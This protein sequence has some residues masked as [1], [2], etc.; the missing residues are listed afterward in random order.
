[1]RMHVVQHVPFEGPAAIANWAE[2]RGVEITASLALT[3]EYPDIDTVDFLVLMGGPMDAD[4]HF[5]SPWLEAEKTYVARALAE[6]RRVLGVCLGAQIVAEAIGGH[7]RRNDQ[8]EIG[9]FAL[10][11]NAAADNDPV[12]A[13]LPEALIAGHWHGD[14]F[15][16]PAGV[17]PAL[18]S[19]GTVCQAF[20][21]DRGRV[22]G[23]QFHLEWTAE[24]LAALLYAAPEDLEERS[25]LVMSA[26]ELE[27]GVQLHS[28]AC[29]TAL[30][31]LL[32]S[33]AAHREA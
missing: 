21:Y 16:L 30:W 14:T 27:R 15:D 24:S 33:M 12:F 26:G 28:A 5:S 6:G 32:D 19:E 1:M 17:E 22:V 9:W 4:D 20:S 2:Q 29:H 8:A 7:V 11:R 18:S 13:A 3:E 23:L 31:R 25:P 10:Q